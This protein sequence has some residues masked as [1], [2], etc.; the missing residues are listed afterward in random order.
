MYLFK[1]G[2]SPRSTGFHAFDRK[3][4]YL[5]HQICIRG[6]WEGIVESFV[7]SVTFDKAEEKTKRTLIKIDL[8]IIRYTSEDVTIFD[9]ATPR[10][11]L[12]ERPTRMEPL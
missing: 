11:V 5:E 8:L 6:G 3:L 2:F 4:Q 12:E 10:R 7:S 1:H 9:A